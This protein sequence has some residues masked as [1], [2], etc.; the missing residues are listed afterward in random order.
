VLLELKEKVIFVRN[1]SKEKIMMENRR[2]K[3]KST[4]VRS[5]IKTYKPEEIMASGGASAFSAMTKKQYNTRKALKSLSE[6]A[7]S[8]EEVTT[9]IQEIKAT[10]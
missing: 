9:A 7:L 10:K 2:V 5:K 6:I 3:S 1:F 4:L 8:E